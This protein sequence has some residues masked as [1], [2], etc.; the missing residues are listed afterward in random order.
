[1]TQ[2][3]AGQFLTG[4]APWETM[5]SYHDAS[6]PEL[7]V[8][9]F[10]HDVFIDRLVFTPDK[11]MVKIHIQIVNSFHKRQG[12]VNKDIVDIKGMLW[13]LKATFVQQLCSVNQ[14]VHQK[15]FPGLSLIHI[16]EPTRLGMISYA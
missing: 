5:T 15:I 13:Q 2:H 10:E 8:D 4:Y 6:Y 12:L 1:M 9:S 3:I 7:L 16:S 14:R 11:I